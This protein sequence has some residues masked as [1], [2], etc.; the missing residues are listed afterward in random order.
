MTTVYVVT[1]EE[2]YF[3]GYYLGGIFSS[4]E[5]LKKAFPIG[6]VP[7][8][9][10]RMRDTPN[11]PHNVEYYEEEIP[12]HFVADITKRFG[13]KVHLDAFPVEMNTVFS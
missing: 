7:K 3:S 8:I 11:D 10:G 9:G 2:D 12:G 4:M 6:W 13:I 1:E 5:E